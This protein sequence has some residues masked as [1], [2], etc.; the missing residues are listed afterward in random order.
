MS[1]TKA[2]FPLVLTAGNFLFFF[3]LST[4]KMKFSSARWCCET[5]SGRVP[6]SPRHR[7]V[8]PDPLCGPSAH[9]V[10]GACSARNSSARRAHVAQVA[11]WF[12]GEAP[13]GISTEPGPARQ[14]LAACPAATPRPARPRSPARPR[15]A[16]AGAAGS[17]RAPAPQPARPAPP[18]PR[19][20]P[21][22]RCR[23]RPAAA[24]WPST[25]HRRLRPP[26][27]LPLATPG[28]PTHT[29][30]LRSA[31]A[32]LGARSA[33]AARPSC[34][35]LAPPPARGRNPGGGGG[36]R[37]GAIADRGPMKA[38]PGGLGRVLGGA[39]P[40]RGGTK[41]GVA[42]FQLVHETMNEAIGSW[43][44]LYVSDTY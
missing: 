18:R 1:V 33:G 41:G 28:L 16:A 8:L 7:P 19:R 14:P 42:L 31:P 13:E 32:G 34:Q 11:G 20:T 24:S 35:P 4:S 26:A 5:C 25:S 39:G 10:Q 23:R 29:G 3:F 6:V 9:P 15:P 17:P 43:G 30:I 22:R 40:G 12:W 27:R 21:R 37:G 38:G 2:S 36:R 44:R